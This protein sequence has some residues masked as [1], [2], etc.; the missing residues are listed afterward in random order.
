MAKLTE[1]QRTDLRAQREAGATLSS[2]AESF[3]V[4]LSTAH[5]IV[6]AGAQTDPA[7]VPTAPGELLRAVIVAGLEKAFR[8]P[9]NTSAADIAALVRAHEQAASKM[10]DGEDEQD[11]SRLSADEILIG[12]HITSLILGEPPALDP[13]EYVRACR[14]V[15]ETVTR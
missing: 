9:D 6:N 5:A 1:T 4:S 14:A 11:L 12:R 15:A 10:A 7:P 13:I 2:L 8:D 3:G